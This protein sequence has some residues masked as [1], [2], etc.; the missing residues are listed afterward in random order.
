[1]SRSDIAA[2]S[3]QLRS[4]VQT[5]IGSLGERERERERGAL[6]SAFTSHS[7]RQNGERTRMSDKC[8]VIPVATSARTPGRESKSANER[9]PIQ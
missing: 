1:M 4:G 2:E 8:V 5:A 6:A 3:F 7:I 9:A